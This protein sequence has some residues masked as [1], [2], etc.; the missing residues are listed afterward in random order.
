MS[1]YTHVVVNGAS[2]GANEIVA[3]VAGYRIRVMGGHFVCDAAVTVTW[4]SAT[5][6]LSAASSYAANGGPVLPIVPWPRADVLPPDGWL[7][8]AAGEALNMVLGGAVGVRG[9]L[10]Y[11][12][13]K[14]ADA[15]G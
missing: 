2:S 4:K 7:E 6:A 10:K 3:A 12:L 1:R 8:T 15:A 9:W 14:D 5:T 13:V 11:V